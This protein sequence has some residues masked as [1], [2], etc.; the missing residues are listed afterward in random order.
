MLEKL[1]THNVKDVSELFSLADKCARAVGGRAWHSQPT[2]EVGKVGKPEA[3]AAAQSSG[4]NKNSEKKSNNNN[5]KPLAGA[6]TTA[7]VAA[8]TG[9]GHGPCGDKRPRQPSDSNEGEPR[10]PVHNSRHHSAEECW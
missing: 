1:A 9:G 5:N 2:L 8:A 3:D 6:P 10:C 4:K 7:S